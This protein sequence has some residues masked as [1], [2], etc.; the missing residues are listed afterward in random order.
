L[1][2]RNHLITAQAQDGAGG[3]SYAYAYVIAND[4]SPPV[5]DCPSLIPGT[6]LPYTNPA[7][8]AQMDLAY[9][10]TIYLEIIGHSESRGYHDEL[11]AL[12]DA[13][14]PGGR[15]YVVTNHWIGGHET[16]EWT[17]P[18]QAG[19][20]AVENIINNIQG[21]TIALILTSN[22]ATY[23]IHTPNMSNT[24]YARFVNECI[25]LADHLYNSGAG[26]IMCYFSAHRMKPAKLMPCYHEN[27]AMFDVMSSAGSAGKGYIKSGPEQHD[28]HWCCYP[29]CYDT[30]FAHTNQQGDVLMAEAWFNLLTQELIFFTVTVDF[31]LDGDV[32][33]EDF[34]VFQAC[35][36]GTGNGPPPTGC[37]N[38]DVDN[39]NDV[40]S[41]DFI[42][43][44]PCI[45]GPNIPVNQSCLN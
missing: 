22:N 9:A 42:L 36:T 17:T 3:S 26:A 40:D 23:P 27:L 43:F 25:S 33:H 8:P 41:D 10:S 32:D 44:E 28:L 20:Q 21:P 18:G 37:N 29:D 2:K 4:Q 35:M 7:A 1:S 19:Y 30:D 14:P 6:P 31:D 12:L 39:D 34:G 16:F 5:P 11:Q 24:N 15:N 45:S 38:A 13:N